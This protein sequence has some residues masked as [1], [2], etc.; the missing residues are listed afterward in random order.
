[1]PMRMEQVSTSVNLK[2]H[3]EKVTFVRSMFCRQLKQRYDNLTRTQLQGWPFL[4]ID[5]R[6]SVDGDAAP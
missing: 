5:L 4:A 3:R 1:M 2:N 6:A